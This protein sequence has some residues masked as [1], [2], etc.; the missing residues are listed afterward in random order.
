M[1]GD[2]VIQDSPTNAAA[3]GDLDDSVWP[4]RYFKLGGRLKQRDAL[5]S[6]VKR[7]HTCVLCGEPLGC[8]PT[9]LEHPLP[10]WLHRFAGE[11]SEDRP[12]SFR[13]PGLGSPTWRQ[14]CLASHQTCNSEFERRIERPAMGPLKTIVKGGTLSWS[15]LDR[16][17]DWFDKVMSAG[18]HMGTA[19]TEH[20]SNFLY[21]QTN[22]PHKRV[23]LFDRLAI[24]FK[25]TGPDD[26]LEL[27]HLLNDGFLT[28]PSAMLLTIGNTG[29][30]YVSNNHLLS[31]AFGL[32][33]PYKEGDI[34][35]Y[36]AGSG[37]FGD[38]LLD[39]I[40]RLPAAKLIAQPMRR[41]H[42]RLDMVTPHPA[43]QSNGDGKVFE[44]K[45]GRWMR[46]TNC[47][48]SNL[49]II[50]GPIAIALASLEIIEWLILMKERD[51]QIYPTVPRIF[52]EPMRQLISEKTDILRWI[53]ML[54][55]GLAITESDRPTGRATPGSV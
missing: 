37:I 45:A 19:L 36:R 11:A 15:D 39:R 35:G 26:G 30:I 9:N 55:G 22:F 5:K 33:M 50:D 6:R 53:T 43:L 46:V 54:R 7:S 12:L 52:M 48:F 14:L 25:M 20:R 42:Q 10:Q 1:G 32:G 34:Y 40:T 17:F 44:L 47:S 4:R 38:N 27:G 16:V 3:F 51:D 24:F 49:P 13:A 21:L 29:I 18:A 31:S 23:G 8:A 41:Q 28:T 2:G